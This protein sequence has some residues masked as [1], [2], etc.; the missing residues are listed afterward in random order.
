[1]P[2]KTELVPI[3]SPTYIT[4]VHAPIVDTGCDAIQEA[5]LILAPLRGVPPV[6][7]NLLHLLLVLKEQRAGVRC[8]VTVD[9]DG[10]YI[11]AVED[12]CG[13]SFSRW[14]ICRR[15]LGI[16]TLLCSLLWNEFCQ[17]HFFHLSK[18]FLLLALSL[19]A[20]SN[21]LS[22]PEARV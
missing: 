12:L 5:K 16:H 14:I 1:M 2:F 17:R 21:I 22:Q 11:Q 20:N 4:L 7:L 6:L 13:D 19:L 9:L 15:L 18:H 10:V 8:A 3:Q